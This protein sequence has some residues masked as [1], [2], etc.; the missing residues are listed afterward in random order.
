MPPRRGRKRHAEPEPEPEP[1]EEEE[2]DAPEGDDEGD[3]DDSSEDA[4]WPI[5]AD[6]ADAD[7]PVP[8]TPESHFVGHRL[9]HYW[10]G[11]NCWYFGRVLSCPPESKFGGASRPGSSLGRGA[12]AAV[13]WTVRGGNRAASARRGRETFA[14]VR[15]GTT[16]SRSSTSS[17][18]TTARSTR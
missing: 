16:R 12:A 5:Q 18:T 15:K 14:R 2:V 7:T 6:P 11:D 1:E 13:G 8:V 3:G 17:C 4:P 9:R 10:A